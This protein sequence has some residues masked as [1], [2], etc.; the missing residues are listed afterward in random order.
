[1]E[2]IVEILENWKTL[3]KYV[4]FV[5]RSMN[6]S[7]TLREFQKFTKNFGMV[8]VINKKFD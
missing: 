4:W 8:I 6:I 2:G 1:M 3:D 7:D 5:C